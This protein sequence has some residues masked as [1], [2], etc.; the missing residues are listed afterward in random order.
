M[1]KLFSMLMLLLA[2]ASVGVFAA[3]T[4]AGTATA[5]AANRV[6]AP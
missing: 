6:T 1:R 4:P 5:A 3:D 2:F